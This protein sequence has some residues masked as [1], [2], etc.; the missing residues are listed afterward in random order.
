MRRF[1]HLV[2]RATLGKE[3]RG[4]ERREGEREEKAGESRG[5]ETR[6][7]CRR[8]TGGSALSK[9]SAQSSRTLIDLPMHM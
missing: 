1:T 9:S 4:E 8:G 2:C 7:L 3:S 5:Q 6:G